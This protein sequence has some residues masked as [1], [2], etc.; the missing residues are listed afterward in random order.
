MTIYSEWF[1][2][3][4]RKVR[5]KKPNRLDETFSTCVIGNGIT[6]ET[7]GNQTLAPQAN[8]CHENFEKIVQSASQKQI[9]G[10]VTDNRNGDAFDSA[11]NAVESCM[12]DAILTAMNYVLI[13]RVEMAVRSVRGSS[14][15]GPNSLLQNL[16]RRDVP[17]TPKIF[18]PVVFKP[19]RFEY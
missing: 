10:S 16:D 8:Y 11:V 15:N 17:V 2:R 4:R 18:A 14:R 6:L 19:V 13:P 7:L 12:H 5:T 3:E 9:R 1:P